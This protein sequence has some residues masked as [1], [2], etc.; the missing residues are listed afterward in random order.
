MAPDTAGTRTA[1]AM[2]ILRG[3]KLLPRGKMFAM[4]AGF[5]AAADDQAVGEGH[6][7]FEIRCLRLKDFRR[8]DASDVCEKFHKRR[9]HRLARLR[10]A[11]ARLQRTG[12]F[13][14]SPLRCKRKKSS[15]FLPAIFC[16]ISKS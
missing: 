10:K 3:S 5:G 4:L 1:V 2:T 7:V 6:R 16:E 8:S 14:I 13:L 11:C 9:P 12:S 15:R